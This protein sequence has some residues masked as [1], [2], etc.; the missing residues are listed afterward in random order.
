MGG[1]AGVLSLWNLPGLSPGAEIPFCFGPVGADLPADFPPPQDF[2]EK[3]LDSASENRAQVLLHR[4]GPWVGRYR[5][6]QRN[7]CAVSLIR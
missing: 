2:C 7:F 6:L 5:Q 1:V 4:C 3:G